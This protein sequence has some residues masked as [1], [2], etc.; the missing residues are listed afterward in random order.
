[1]SQQPSL[2]RV[3]LTFVRPELNNGSDVAPATIVRVWPGGLV[4]LKVHLDN[5]GDLWNTS[6][7]LFDSRE[8]AEASP[9]FVAGAPFAAYWPPRV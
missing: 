2:G 8:A 1:M 4:N 7:P 9:S 3:V 5:T 6:V